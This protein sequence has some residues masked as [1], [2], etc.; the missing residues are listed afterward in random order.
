[1]KVRAHGKHNGFAT[2]LAAGAKTSGKDAEN[3]LSSDYDPFA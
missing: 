2:Y 1:M 3:V